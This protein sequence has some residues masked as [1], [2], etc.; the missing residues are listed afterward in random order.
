MALG[1][2]RLVGGPLCAA[3][4]LGGGLVRSDRT[5]H[6]L[7]RLL[8]ARRRR[9]AMKAAHNCRKLARIARVRENKT[10]LRLIIYGHG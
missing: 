1:T 8:R 10:A 2:I 4:L 3:Q 6:L 5:G 7:Q 9:D